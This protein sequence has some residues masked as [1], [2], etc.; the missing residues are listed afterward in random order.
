MS[1]KVEGFV[2]HIY[3]NAFPGTELVFLIA[4]FN[5]IKADFTDIME[6]GSD[7]QGFCA[8]FSCFFFAI[9]GEHGFVQCK[10]VFKHI[11]GVL[12]QAAFI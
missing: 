4:V 5:P 9:R 10:S 3:R 12:A 11:N 6:Q 2:D 7:A 1:A 8:E